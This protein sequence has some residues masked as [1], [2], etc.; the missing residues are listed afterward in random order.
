[1]GAVQLQAARPLRSAVFS[2]VAAML[3]F[4]RARFIARRRAGV[5]FFRYAFFA[6]LYAALAL[7][8]T[9]PRLD[10]CVVQYVQVAAALPGS[11]TGAVGAVGEVAVGVG[12]GV[13][14][15]GALY[16]CSAT[17]CRPDCARL[18]PRQILKEAP[19][20]TNVSLPVNVSG[21]SAFMTSPTQTRLPA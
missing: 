9:F 14:G 13:A 19:L 20:G 18:M 11:L 17:S 15:A 4:V 21:A 16:T 6:L 2:F 5:R 12:A 10:S 1:M 8:M 7:F 3:N